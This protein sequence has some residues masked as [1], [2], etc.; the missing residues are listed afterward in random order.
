MTES[1]VA[2]PLAMPRAKAPSL[3]ALLREDLNCVFAR[4]PAARNRLEV[5]LTYPGL[6]AIVWHRVA[7]VLWRQGWRFSAR[8]LAFIAR[9][10]SNV[11]IHPGATIGRRFFID[12]GAGVVIGGT[13]EIGDDVTLYQGVTL[14]GVSL[15][16]GKRHPTL[17][18]GVIVGAG[19]KILGAIHIG[20]R[21]RVGANSVVVK[22]VPDECTVVGIPARVV[23]AAAQN[24][25]DGILL[26]YNRL[27]DPV[28]RSLHCLMQRIESLEA[29]LQA[30]KQGTPLADSPENQGESCGVCVAG[31][32]C[33]EHV[34]DG[35]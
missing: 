3:F 32:L 33:C 26:D 35:D 5:L 12:H 14:G 28:A 2:F 29:E 10:L 1:A 11:D 34:S 15:N 25:D 24:R 13:T 20:K 16:K 8:L 23:A 22:N 21:V 6:H 9:A 31:A 7:H 18:D 4:D 19:A 27:P 17:G 30:M